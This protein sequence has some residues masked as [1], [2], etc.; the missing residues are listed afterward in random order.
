[1]TALSQQSSTRPLYRTVQH[2]Q[3]LLCKE[4][5]PTRV[6][7]GGVELCSKPTLYPS[8]SESNGA[9]GCIRVH[10]VT[11]VHGL[12]ASSF[13]LLSKIVVKAVT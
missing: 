11:A 4:V 2:V 5:H 6:E 10:A 9:T 1:V 3:Q 12:A 7:Q 13:A 8:F